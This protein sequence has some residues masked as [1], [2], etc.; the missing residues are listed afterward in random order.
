M[1]CILVDA[2]VVGSERHQKN[3]TNLAGFRLRLFRETS[4]GRR[5]YAAQP[6]EEG[7]DSLR[8]QYFPRG[9]SNNKPAFGCP[10]QPNTQSGPKLPPA[11]YFH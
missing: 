5:H 11:K 10:R 4:R 8:K 7:N 3:P 2:I 6:E 9:G 1:S